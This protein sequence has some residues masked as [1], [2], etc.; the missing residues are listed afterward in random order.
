MGVDVDLEGLRR[1]VRMPRAHGSVHEAELQPGLA[2]RDALDVERKGSGFVLEERRDALVL[3]L[4]LHVEILAE[5]HGSAVD[6]HEPDVDMGGR[7]ADFDLELVAP[8]PRGAVVGRD[9]LC[10]QHQLN[11]HHVVGVVRLH[12]LRLGRAVTARRKQQAPEGQGPPQ[13]PGTEIVLCSHRWFPL[14]SDPRSARGAAG[15]SV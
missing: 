12:R 4:D 9:R 15:K 2:L 11:A 10:A 7:L 14:C 13:A 6:V 1:E 5:R 3:G 8:R